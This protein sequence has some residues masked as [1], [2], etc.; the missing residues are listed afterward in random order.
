MAKGSL[1]G[2]NVVKDS[3]IF[4]RTFYGNIALTAKVPHICSAN[5]NGITYGS[6]E[7]EFT[8]RSDAAKILTVKLGKAC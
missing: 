4:F 5:G 7:N 1:D 6:D 8:V 3:T 2:G